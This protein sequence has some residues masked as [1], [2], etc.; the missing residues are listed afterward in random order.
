MWFFSDLFNHHWAQALCGNRKV[1][2][3]ADCV[4]NSDKI[5]CSK[6]IHIIGLIYI[7][8]C[9]SSRF[10]M[11]INESTNE[12]KRKSSILVKKLEIKPSYVIFHG[13]KTF[14]KLL[15]LTWNI[16]DWNSFLQAPVQYFTKARNPIC[17]IPPLK[18][19]NYFPPQPSRNDGRSD[20]I[21]TREEAGMELLGRCSVICSSSWQGMKKAR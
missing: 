18:W 20:F 10:L 13:K 11:K 1:N 4:D 5:Y 7:T 6:F 8:P 12:Q 16:G 19:D 2:Y 21:L 9:T 17:L 14:I 3:E 15:S